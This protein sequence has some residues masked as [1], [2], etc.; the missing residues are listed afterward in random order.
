MKPQTRKTT[1]ATTERKTWN[2]WEEVK[3]NCVESETEVIRDIPQLGWTFNTEEGEKK[4][5]IQML[6]G[7]LVMASIQKTDSQGTLYL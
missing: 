4:S 2:S 6:T 5:I 1:A 7:A 3:A